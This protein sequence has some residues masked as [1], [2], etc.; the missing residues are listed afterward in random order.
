MDPDRD[1]AA[2]ETRPQERAAPMRA[3]PAP[4]MDRH[5]G[6]REAS[7]SDISVHQRMAPMNRIPPHADRLN[8]T[9]RSRVTPKG[10]FLVM[11]LFPEGDQAFPE[12]DRHLCLALV[13]G[14]GPAGLDA[15]G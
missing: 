8:T 2:L 1:Q 13:Q 9:H 6:L 11:A 12:V 4:V 7:N 14:R 15:G 10:R 5:T 3:Q